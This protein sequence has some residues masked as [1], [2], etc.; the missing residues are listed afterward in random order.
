M[1]LVQRLVML[2]RSAAL[3]V[4]GEKA[5]SVIENGPAGVFGAGGAGA[6]AAE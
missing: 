4:A 6:A 1:M 3:S 5:V 2:T